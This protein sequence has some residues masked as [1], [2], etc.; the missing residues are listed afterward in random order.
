MGISFSL[1]VSGQ[2]HDLLFPPVLTDLWSCTLRSFQKQVSKRLSDSNIIRRLL[3][4]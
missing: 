4:F 1:C 2:L 3:T